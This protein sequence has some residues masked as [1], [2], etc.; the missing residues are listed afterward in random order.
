MNTLEFYS[1]D[2][3]YEYLKKAGYKKEKQNVIAL[4]V[5][6][7]NRVN[8]DPDFSDQ[9]RILERN[10]QQST[11]D[12]SSIA[13]DNITL[14]MKGSIYKSPVIT[15]WN[16]FI[17]RFK[18]NEISQ[19]LK[20]KSK[21]ECKILLNKSQLMNDEYYDFISEKLVYAAVLYFILYSCFRRG[22]ASI[23]C[24]VNAALPNMTDP[25]I[26][27]NK[28]RDIAENHVKCILTLLFKSYYNENYSSVDD[29]AHANRKQQIYTFTLLAIVYKYSCVVNQEYKSELN[30]YINTTSKGHPKC[31][32][33][34]STLNI[35]ESI[36]ERLIDNEEL[37]KTLIMLMPEFS[38]YSKSIK[39]NIINEWS[40]NKFYLSIFQTKNH[41][42]TGHWMLSRSYALHK[43]YAKTP[44]NK[45]PIRK[46]GKVSQVTIMTASKR[47]F[48]EGLKLLV[49]TGKFNKGKVFQG[50]R[51]KKAAYEY[52]HKTFVEE[53][54][55]QLNNRFLGEV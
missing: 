23:D 28:A 21:E 25:E 40:N 48:S 43:A 47:F 34:H 26:S 45:F 44:I 31:D 4:I 5:T 11:P 14:Y 20:I 35:F 3:I 6:H 50:E 12:K 32:I 22:E 9:M 16:K 37:L 46:K 51:Y 30:N 15:Q 54:Y 13:I 7:F 36:R 53:I 39:N 49:T 29:E 41:F 38:E 17:S 33:D 18:D 1:I 8:S 55:R 52:I 19:R 42:I 27:R 10:D 24:I 2:T